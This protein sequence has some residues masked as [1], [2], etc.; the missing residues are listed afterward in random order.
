MHSNALSL[1]ES[2]FLHSQAASAHMYALDHA[3]Y[4]AAAH[5]PRRACLS[6]LLRC[7]RDV[8]VLQALAPG[9]PEA[10]AAASDVFFYSSVCGREA[11][12]EDAPSQA[13][14]GRPQRARMDGA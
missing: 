5:L 12:S 13:Q 14:G 9:P 3:S 8:T 6:A 11:G 4:H 1:L 2:K 7:F 10:A